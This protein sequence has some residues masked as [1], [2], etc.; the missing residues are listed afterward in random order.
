MFDSESDSLKFN[1]QRALINLFEK[2]GTEFVVDRI[3]AADDCLSEF[4]IRHCGPP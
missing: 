3:G 2:A 1:S 4:V